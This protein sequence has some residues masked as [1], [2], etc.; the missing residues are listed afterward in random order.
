MNYDQQIEIIKAAKEGKKI[1]AVN[2]K[3]QNTEILDP[4]CADKRVYDK[5]PAL[6]NFQ[7]YYYYVIL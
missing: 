3:T 2:I 4:R 1:V 7:D 5:G 6:F